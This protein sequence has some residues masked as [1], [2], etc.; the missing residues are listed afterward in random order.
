MACRTKDERR[1]HRSSETTRLCKREMS[2]ASPQLG[3]CIP[4]LPCDLLLLLLGESC[5]LIVL[6]PN[7][8]DG[9]LQISRVCGYCK[10]T[11]QE[12]NRRLV[13][14]SRLTIPLFDRIPESLRQY[15]NISMADSLAHSVDLRDRSNMNRIATASLQTK[16]S[17][18]QMESFHRLSSL[19]LI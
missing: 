18:L 2:V 5:K 12:R 13:E 11:Y 6:C 8:H 15:C 19:P 4:H 1:L 9:Q 3:V 17:M 16:G 14:A 10:A 7:L